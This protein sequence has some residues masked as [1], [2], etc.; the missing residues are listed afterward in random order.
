MED[1]LQKLTQKLYEEGLSKGRNDADDLVAKAKEEARSII[2]EA[3]VKAQSIISEAERNA[4]ELKKNT[5]TEVALASRQVIATLKEQIQDLVTA[6]ELAPTMH[7]AVRNTKFLQE[8]I[9]EVS[10]NW[11]GSEQGKADLE[12]MLPAGAPEQLVKELQQALNNALHADVEVKANDRVKSGFR[13]APKAGGYYISFTDEDFVALFR[14]Y[15]R[16]KVAALLF[17]ESK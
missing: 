7:E 4:E 8:M 13:V 5:E 6:K 14:D 15:V 1:K 2:N 12:V 11:S 10:K 16:P 3:K 9:L 17:G